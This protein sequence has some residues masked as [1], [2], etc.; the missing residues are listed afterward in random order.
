MER[1]QIGKEQVKMSLMEDDM[2]LY[3]KNIAD[4]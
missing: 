2:V 1:I 3:I 4:H